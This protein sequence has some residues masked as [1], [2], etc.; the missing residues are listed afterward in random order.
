MPDPRRFYRLLL[1]LYPARFREEYA[2]PL[3]QQFWDDYRDARGLRAK[4]WFWLRAV[5]DLAWSIPGEIAGEL[6]QDVRYAARIYRQRSISTALALVAL[7]LGI[8]ATTGVFSVVNALLLRSLP[9]RDPG[10]LVELWLPA[11]NALNGRSSFRSWVERSPYLTAASGYHVAEMTLGLSRDAARVRVAET[12]ADFFTVLGTQ[13]AIG[14]PFAADEDSPGRDSVAIL[15]HALWEQAFGGDPRVLGSSVNINGVP[16]TVIG[17]APTG[18]DFPAHTALWTPT[19]FDLGRL[20]KSGALFLRHLGRLKAGVSIAQA[21]SA[22]DGE[23]RVVYPESL[24]LDGGNRPRLNSLRDQLAGPARNASMV[25]L[26]VVAFVLS[27]ACANVAHLLLSR[28]TERRQELMVR[29]ALGAS[30]GRLVQQLVTECTLLTL[31][32]A[33]AGILVAHWGASLANGAQPS[34]LGTQ[35]YT[36]LDWRVLGF[37]LALAAVT[38]L[39]FGVLPASLM[40]RMQPTGDLARVQTDGRTA[41]PRR[42][43]T[44]LVVM[45]AAF[46]LMLLAGSVTMGRTFLKL[47]GADLGFRSDHAVTFSVALTGTPHENESLRAKYYTDVLDRLRAIPGV[48]SAGA[49]EYLPLTPDLFFMAGSFRLGNTSKEN[50]ASI[51]S[52]TPGYFSAMGTRFILGRD[53]TPQDQ[54]AAIVTEDFAKPLGGAATVLGRKLVSPFDAKWLAIVG[55]VRPAQFRP[56]AGGMPQVFV[57][58]TLHIPVNLTFVARVRG[59][60]EAYLPVGRDAIRSVDPKAPVFGGK[61]LEK[62]L[63]ESLANARFY[64]TVVMFFG[65]F[66]L[67]LAVIG[68]YSVASFLVAQRTH[69]IGVRLAVGAS[70]ERLRVALL[71]ESLM[72]VAG[73]AAVGVAGAMALGRLVQHLIERSDPI[74]VSTCWVATLILAA[75]AGMAI[76]IASKR[77]VRL[78]P[79]RVLR[80]D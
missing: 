72:P 28:V 51:N 13:P 8:G 9:F 29:A 42:L 55:V 25:L 52:A 80:A 40:G 53:F 76:W 67:L 57:P 19:A 65:F 27:I 30:R 79:M 7:A 39:V 71:R 45:Q 74:G 61:T 35:T 36:V 2:E 73:G 20:P 14:R 64:V 59:R 48:E 58:A 47:L 75:T 66:A 33:G 54:Y 63:S 26:G 18:L 24:K 15:S 56:G 3:E 49:A 12:S 43:R 32:A 6:R 23:I 62:K 10:R 5:A 69:E 77:I 22:F 16:M 41:G 1:K 4:T 46:T 21:S 44:L 60:A 50:R 38:G 78:D 34:N 11:V 68:V 37:A 31:A 17:V 70:P